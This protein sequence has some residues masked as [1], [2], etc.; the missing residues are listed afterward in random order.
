MER[1]RLP[2]ERDPEE[3]AEKRGGFASGYETP[4]LHKRPG[5]RTA[6]RAAVDAGLKTP[7]EA[8]KSLAGEHGGEDTPQNPAMT[9]EQVVAENQRA[10]NE[11]MGRDG[12]E[13]ETGQMSLPIDED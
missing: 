4:P 7:E 6:V 13:T 12:E 5:Y 3:Q 8:A 1:Q 10:W 9:Q 11:M 2:S